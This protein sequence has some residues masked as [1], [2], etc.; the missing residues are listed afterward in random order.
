MKTRFTFIGEYVFEFVDDGE[1]RE[2]NVL[3]RPDKEEDYEVVAV[4]PGIPEPVVSSLLAA[5]TPVVEP[6]P[7]T[8]KRR[9]LMGFIRATWFVVFTMA[10]EALTYGLNNLTSFNLPPGTATA[11]G[12][13]GYG[14]KRAAWPDSTV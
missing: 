2:Y 14:L 11:I 5:P 3:V 1:Y 7:P 4:S 9:T 10:G 8:K 12:A 13:V 6:V